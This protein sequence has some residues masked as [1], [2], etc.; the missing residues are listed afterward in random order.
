MSFIFNTRESFLYK[1]PKFY[2]KFQCPASLK[3]KIRKVSKFQYNW[4]I[5]PIIMCRY[6][7]TFWFPWGI[8]TWSIYLFVLWETNA[9]I[10][11]FSQTKKGLESSFPQSKWNFLRIEIL[12]IPLVPLG[13]SCFF[14]ETFLLVS[15]TIE[16]VHLKDLICQ[17]SETYL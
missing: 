1:V 4:S 12:K 8:S 13:V 5:Y 6:S 2:T 15:N 11:V 3:Q 7:M 10:T 16:F 17:A 9:S 14:F